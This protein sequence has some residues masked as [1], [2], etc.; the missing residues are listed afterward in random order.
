MN[1]EGQFANPILTK[2]R[3]AGIDATRLRKALDAKDNWGG[4]IH[5]FEYLTVLGI[6]ADAFKNEED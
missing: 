1:D 5:A 4:M 6:V 2:C 3:E